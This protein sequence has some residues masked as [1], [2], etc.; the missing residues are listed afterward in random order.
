MNVVGA[1]RFFR[2][3][4]AGD[5]G[6]QSTTNIGWSWRRSGNPG[7][8]EQDVI[9]LIHVIDAADIEAGAIFA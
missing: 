5:P 4:S 1:G 2:E 8:L 6:K 3:V 7:R 9:V